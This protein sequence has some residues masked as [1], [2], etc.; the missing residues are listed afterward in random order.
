MSDAAHVG[1]I[2]VAEVA[3][4]MAFA[5]TGAHALFVGWGVDL[6][7]TLGIEPL[8]E[9]AHDHAHGAVDSVAAHDHGVTSSFEGAANHCPEGVTGH[10]HGD[11]WACDTHTGMADEPLTFIN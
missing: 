4:T 5:L 9:G 1:Q 3:L 6:G 10:W 11:V 2:A 7:A 8:F